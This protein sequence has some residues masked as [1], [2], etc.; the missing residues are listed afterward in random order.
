MTSGRRRVEV[1]GRQPLTKYAFT[2]KLPTHNLTVLR[3]RLRDA[4][5]QPQVWHLQFGFLQHTA[6]PVRYCLPRGSTQAHTAWPTSI[7]AGIQFTMMY[8]PLPSVMLSN[9]VA[10]TNG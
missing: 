7:Y 2:S 5:G 8:S 6:Y 9:R 3:T 1:S 10:V 4:V